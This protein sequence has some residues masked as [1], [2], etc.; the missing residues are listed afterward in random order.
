[1]DS[2]S[3]WFAQQKNDFDSEHIY[4][5]VRTLTPGSRPLLVSECGGYSR[6]ID[7]HH[8]SKYSTY[9][10]C[11]AETA[12]ELTAMI[13]RMYEDMILPAIPGGCCGCVYAQLSDVEDEVN[14]LYTYDRKVCKVEKAPLQ[15][16]AAKLK[17]SE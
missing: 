3:G 17:I 13:C 9:G 7:G 10:Y 15:E 4:F 8:Y 12:K 14:G 6:L 16:L 11:S 2:A 1:M 5:D